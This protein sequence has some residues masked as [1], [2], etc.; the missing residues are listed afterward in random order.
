MRRD[1]EGGEE[2]LG[3]VGVASPRARERGGGEEGRRRRGCLFEGREEGEREREKQE[4]KQRERERESE[5]ERELDECEMLI[6]SQIE[7]N[8]KRSG[9]APPSIHPVPPPPTLRVCVVVA[10]VVVLHGLEES[11]EVNE[12]NETTFG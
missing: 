10:L 1:S 8:P 5:R 4:R 6:P 11:G 7:K 2:G 3:R 12:K 9:K